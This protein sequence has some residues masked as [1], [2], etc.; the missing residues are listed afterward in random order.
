MI[1]IEFRQKKQLIDIAIAG[2]LVQM[3]V[4][5]QPPIDELHV[6]GNMRHPT[7]NVD[8]NQAFRSIGSG[9]YTLDFAP[10]V[11]GTYEVSV[12]ARRRGYRPSTFTRNLYCKQ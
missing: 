10:D 2:T 1:W 11:A 3:E 6:S 7:G 9:R 8:V 12:T 4:Y 5:T